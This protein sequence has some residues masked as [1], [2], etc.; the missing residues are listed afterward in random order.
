MQRKILRTRW[1]RL[2]TIIKIIY[3]L[4]FL[5]INDPTNWKNSKTIHASH[6][7]FLF[8]FSITII[9]TTFSPFL[10]IPQILA[11][12]SSFKRNILIFPS[13]LE[14]DKEKKTSL[15]FVLEGKLI[16][17]CTQGGG[18]ERE[19]ERVEQ[20]AKVCF[21]VA[22]HV[23]RSMWTCGLFQDGD[24]VAYTTVEHSGTRGQ[25]FYGIWWKLD[26]EW[27]DGNRAN[28]VL[29]TVSELA[30]SPSS[31]KHCTHIEP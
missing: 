4:R 22:M 16:R 1:T 19:R 23:D 15:N 10:P 26:I 17:S 11:T 28:R 21:R 12:L 25:T 18:G 29:L 5:K 9:V 24:Q 3:E 8:P 30:V 20:K 7:S 14:F 13:V 6:L 31:M 27:L 2:Q